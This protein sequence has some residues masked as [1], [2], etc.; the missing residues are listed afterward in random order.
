MTHTI[1]NPKPVHERAKA[2]LTSAPRNRRDAP[3]DGRSSPLRLLP[4]PEADRDD[5]CGGGQIWILTR[6]ACG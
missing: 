2:A 5:C 1:K 4:V 3:K 6:N